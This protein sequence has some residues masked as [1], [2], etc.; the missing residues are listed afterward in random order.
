[1]GNGTYCV[2]SKTNSIYQ[3]INL[4]IFCAD[5]SWQS[6]NLQEI[7][8]MEIT[9]T[10]MNGAVCTGPKTSRMGLISL[11]FAVIA[12][13]FLYISIHRIAI[14]HNNT[15]DICIVGETPFYNTIH[16]LCSVLPAASATSAIL[17]LIRCRR[18]KT[19]FTAAI[20]AFAGLLL[21]LVSF[22]VYLIALL[23][24]AY[25]HSG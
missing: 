16:A 19:A 23:T 6:Y 13:P 8:M 1:M 15:L 11:A 24:I 14:L 17:S 18:N 4:R 5:I 7:Q 25:S 2:K 20:P 12:I 3:E 9:K 22:T 10:N 21:A